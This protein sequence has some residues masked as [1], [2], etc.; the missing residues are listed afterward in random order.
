MTE[1]EHRRT[2]PAR[3][4][5]VFDVAAAGPT[6]NAWTPDGVEVEPE[7][8]GTLHAWVSSGSEVYD[9]TGYVEADPDALRL[10]WGG[11]EHDYEGWLQVEPDVSTPDRSVATLHLTFG[12][13]Q[14]ETLGGEASEQADR[15][16]AEALDRLAALAVERAGGGSR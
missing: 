16:V 2:I 5:T 3:A 8:P 7:G 12:G 9:A 11:T 1:F 4:R 15:R 6:L 14:P 10:E 13:E